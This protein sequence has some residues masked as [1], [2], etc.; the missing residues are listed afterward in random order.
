M[1]RLMELGA[2]T[3]DLMTR[4][5]QTASTAICSILK[6]TTGVEFKD[7]CNIMSGSYA[8]A[9]ISLLLDWHNLRTD[10][11]MRE[12]SVNHQ[13]SLGRRPSFA[14]LSNQRRCGDTDVAKIDTVEQ[15]LC[16]EVDGVDAADL[17]PNIV[18]SK[19]DPSS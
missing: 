14:F 8:R 7:S 5:S 13:C 10:S 18:S 12:K 6:R 3:K 19:E 17:S 9:R 11:K 4:T 2:Q 1:R 15:L 16:V